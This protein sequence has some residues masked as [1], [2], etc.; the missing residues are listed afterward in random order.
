MAQSLVQFGGRRRHPELTPVAPREPRDFL[1]SAQ[2]INKTSPSSDLTPR[3]STGP[4]RAVSMTRLDQLAQ[5]RQRYLESSLKNRPAGN[6]NDGS[7]NCMVKSMIELPANQTPSYSHVSSRFRMTK[8]MSSSMTQLN[9]PPAAPRPRTS[10][11]HSN[12]SPKPGTF[13]LSRPASESPL[14]KSKSMVHLAAGTPRDTRTTKMRSA[15][16]LNRSTHAL[17]DASC[18]YCA[19]GHA[20]GASRDG[21][22]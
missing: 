22:G 7:T 4:K 17:D 14:A 12:L 5:P 20:S 19:G 10:A 2:R 15:R 3:P 8:G 11:N 21:G 1:L 18:K 6:F 16:K 13:T 9:R